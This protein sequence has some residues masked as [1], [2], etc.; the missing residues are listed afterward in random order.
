M[1]D[2]A[3]CFARH[4]GDE[5]VVYKHVAGEDL[6]LSLYYPPGFKADKKHPAFIV[7]HGGGWAGRKI[8]D[9]QPAWAGDFLGYLARYY[10]DRG[11]VGVSVDYRLMPKEDYGQVPGRQLPDLY[12]DCMDAMDYLADH[13]VQYGL[14]TGNCVL[15]GESAG[16]YLAAAVAAFQ[17]RKNPLTLRA[18]ILVNAITEVYSDKW[19][20]AA[21]EGTDAK[22]LSPL[23]HVGKGTCPALLIHGA[24]DSVVARRHSIAYHEALKAAGV[25]STLCLIPD[26]DH[27]FLL[28]EYSNQLKAAR[29]AIAA[30][31][32]YLEGLGV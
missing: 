18:A 25:P 13:A 30:I 26:T 27:A 20:K 24:E 31:D 10:A 7:I 17:T 6:R 32:E 5:T 9:D 4:S 2:L 16:G 15:L 23:C 22:A 11:F 12:V 29:T 8:F 19:H 3:S 21:P 14:D 28:V 1:M